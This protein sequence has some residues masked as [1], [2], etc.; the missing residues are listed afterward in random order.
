MYSSKAPFRFRWKLVLVTYLILTAFSALYLKFQPEA[1]PITSYSLEAENK[2]VL[3]FFHDPIQDSE[4]LNSS[5]ESSFQILKLNYSELSTPS[6]TNLSD[7]GLHLLDSLKVDEVHVAGKGIGG[8][9]AFDFASRN[10]ERTKSLAVRSANGVVELELLGG[11]HLNQAVYSVKFLAFST[12]KYLTPNFGVFSSLDNQIL[13]ANIQRKSDQ[14]EARNRISMIPGAVLIQHVQGDKISLEASTEHARIIPQSVLKN[15]EKGDVEI[16]KELFSFLNENESGLYTVEITPQRT[17]QALLPFDN[18]NSMKAEGRALIILMLVIIL[19]TLI[20]EDLTCIGTGLLIARGLIGFTP[21]VLACLIGIF[22]GDILLYLSG[23]WLASSTL[24][25]APLRWFI[26]EKDIQKS[27]H[28]F[29]AKGPAIIIASRFI[30]GTRFP[31]Y[32]S[33][34]AIGASFWMFIIYFGIAS[35]IWTPILVGLAVLLGQEMISYFN[36]YQEYALWVLGGVLASL[37]L[38]F[39]IVIPSF[40]FKGRRLLVGK[41]KRIVN[42]EFWPPYIIY[43]FVVIYSFWLWMKY[44]KPGIFVHAN[45]AIPY[46]GFIKE[47]KYQILN[48]ISSSNSVA[49]YS[50]I[51]ASCESKKED[52]IAFM[53]QHELTFPIV[54]KPDVG[55]R[56]KG[57]HIIKNE[58]ALDNLIPSLTTD[59]IIQE[60][61]EGNEYGIFYYRIP[62]EQEGHIFSITEKKYLSVYGDGIHTLEELILKDKR[63]VCMAELH[64]DNHIDE[65]YTIPDKGEEIPLVELGTH[66]RGSVFYDGTS[67]LTKSLH[68][69]IDTI[70]KSFE[71]FYF[72]RYDVKVP[73]EKSLQEGEDIKVIEV[74]GV[75]SESTNI[76]DPKH[77]FFYGLKTLLKQWELVYRIGAEVKKKNQDLKTP[78]LAQMLRLL[79]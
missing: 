48:G 52:I 74:N 75:T 33:A 6:V 71:G 46:G 44:K 16:G 14:R 11:F 57:V 67:L 72:G 12:L 10:P 4:D 38:V 31:T 8:A 9:I 50:F 68:I 29:E 59:H 3:L 19:S 23:K 73:D 79:R 45:P 78:S 32:F 40:T 63:A 51:A 25:R 41:W 47:S 37:Y 55:E 53:N 58:Q 65:L 54:I 2:P 36:I 76:Y 43:F 70:S 18:T 28:W 13:R 61:I 30:P 22:F 35:I 62:G 34:G 20:S 21:G 49:R 66:A 26:S 60:Y 77:S 69:Q 56:G 27:Y 7:Y 24:H 5:L 17:I 64:F 39:K 15:Y 42:W 1:N